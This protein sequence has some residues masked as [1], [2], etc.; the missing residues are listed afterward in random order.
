[1]DDAQV[2]PEFLGR[3]LGKSKLFVG[4][5]GVSWYLEYQL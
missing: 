5:P 2:I 4:G 3:K 1:M